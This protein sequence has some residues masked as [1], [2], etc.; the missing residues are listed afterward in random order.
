M[1]QP[2]LVV[3]VVLMVALLALRWWVPTES[4][5]ATV[6]AQAIDRSAV[7]AARH[8]PGDMRANTS[9]TGPDAKV[10]LP[11]DLAAGTRESESGEPGNAFAVRA[12]PAPP[13]PVAPPPPRAP[14]SPPPFV[15]PLLP[16]PEPPPPPPP[17][18]P[19]QVIGS[20]RDDQGSSVFIAGPSGVLQ[21][22]AGDVL[23]AEY[24]ITQIT[25]QQV[26]LKHLP[27]NRDIPLAVPSAPRP[28]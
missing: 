22:R 1:K 19:L 12:P 11:A 8:A 13:V 14:P 15:G 24:R 7:A 17:P 20:W 28:H 4:G 10:V 23:L 2:R 3:L 21:G 6:V 26:M 27:S 5:A 25:P 9:V 18:P 16:P